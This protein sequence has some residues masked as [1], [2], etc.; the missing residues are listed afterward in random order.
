VDMIHDEKDFEH[1]TGT[2]GKPVQ[3]CQCKRNLVHG[4]SFI[5]RTA[6]RR[7]QS[8]IGAFFVD[9]PIVLTLFSK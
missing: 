9:S 1:N 8:G 2:D 4:M 5:R 7:T 3:L 6:V